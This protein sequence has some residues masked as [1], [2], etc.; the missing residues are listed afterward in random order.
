MESAGFA[1]GPLK[2]MVY[3]NTYIIGPDGYGQNTRFQRHKVQEILRSL[4][5]ERIDKQQYDPRQAAQTAKHIAEDL[6]EKV[7]VLGYDR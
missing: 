5:K 7:K 4:L 6:R 1:G 3:E 2:E